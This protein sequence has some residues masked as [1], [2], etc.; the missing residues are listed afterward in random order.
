ARMKINRYE[1]LVGGLPQKPEWPYN[2]KAVFSPIDV[3]EEYTRPARYVENGT[4]VTRE[5]LTDVEKIEFE[6]AGVLESFNTDGLR[7]LAV[8]LSHV[9]DMKEKTLRYP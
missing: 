8:T 5:A 9:P 6:E 3:I 4:M 7:T 1:C 2:Y